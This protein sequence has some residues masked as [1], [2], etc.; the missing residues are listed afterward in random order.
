MRL[1]TDGVC[2]ILFNKWCLAKGLRT[3]PCRTGSVEFRDMSKNL[4]DEP[5]KIK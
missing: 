5:A 1:L 4:P 2:L 3:I